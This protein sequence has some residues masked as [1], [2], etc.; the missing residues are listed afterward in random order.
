MR[1]ATS[2]DQIA[3][4]KQ[5]IAQWQ[6]VV[7]WQITATSSPAAPANCLLA[8]F[9]SSGLCIKK[10]QPQRAL[11][12]TPQHP[13]NRGLIR[14]G[15]WRMASGLDVGIGCW[16]L[17]GRRVRLFVL[18]VWRWGG[19]PCLGPGCPR[20]FSVN[21]RCP[22]GPTQCGLALRPVL[23]LVPVVL[24]GR[25]GV[26]R[27]HATND[28]RAASRP[29]G[30]LCFYAIGYSQAAQEHALRRL[31]TKREAGHKRGKRSS[32]VPPTPLVTGKFGA[33]PR[34]WLSGLVPISRSQGREQGVT[35]NTH[36]R[37]G[38]QAHGAGISPRYSPPAG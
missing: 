21:V 4:S 10:M 33:F 20:C 31:P 22:C 9:L 28:A 12:N 19:L 32:S 17:G 13:N 15:A 5:Q 38:Q 11:H 29:A 1:Y 26:R 2:R 23:V 30:S 6:W 34:A 7:I 14:G 36:S 35:H 37:E 25:F 27:T 18:L 16:V 8:F 24:R 3:N